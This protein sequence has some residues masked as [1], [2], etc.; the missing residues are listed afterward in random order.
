MFR[1]VVERN[2]VANKFDIDSC[3]T[4]GGSPDWYT[5]GGF[6]YHEVRHVRSSCRACEALG[7][8]GKVNARRWTQQGGAMARRGEAGGCAMVRSLYACGVDRDARQSPPMRHGT[9]RVGA[10]RDG[11]DSV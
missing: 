10:G 3:G 11:V 7:G 2:G 4:G 9:G 8:A 1:A 6:S 5:A